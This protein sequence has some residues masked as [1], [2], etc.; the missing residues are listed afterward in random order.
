MSTTTPLTDN[1]NALTAYANNKTGAS[2]TNLSDAV[3]RLVNGYGSGGGAI[4]DGI[5]VKARNSNGRITEIDYYKSDGKIPQNE[6]GNGRAI[7]SSWSWGALTKINLKGASEF[8]VGSNAFYGCWSLVNIDWDKITSMPNKG[9]SNTGP[10]EM[11][12]NCQALTTV[13]APNLTGG[14]PVYCFYSC[15]NLASVYI[16]KVTALYGYGNNR[17]CLQT[18]GG[19]TLTTVEVGSIGYPVTYIHDYAFNTAMS[20]T[21]T[22]YTDASYI[23]SALSIIRNNCAS[24]TIIIK[25]SEAL[26]YNGTSY[27]AGDTVITSTPSAT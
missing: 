11:F 10:Q 2:D 9:N 26:T 23:D 17:G 21:I 3:T 22:I 5:V 27:A 20:G 6:F 16:P 1:I 18:N 15:P 12:R 24:A 14:L 8:E 13:N 7:N 4:E 19:A 25:A